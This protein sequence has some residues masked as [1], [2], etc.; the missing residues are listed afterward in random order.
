MEAKV[1]QSPPTE[2]SSKLVKKFVRPP[3]CAAIVDPP[4]KVVPP[5]A[6]KTGPRTGGGASAHRGIAATR[7]IART[8]FLDGEQFMG[9]VGWVFW[10]FQLGLEIAKCD[11]PPQ[12]QPHSQH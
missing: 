8:Q 1:H 12:V 2:L 4:V 10:L 5:G 6:G 7:R 11:V 3:A 9:Q